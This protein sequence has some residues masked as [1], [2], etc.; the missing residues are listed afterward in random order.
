MAAAMAVAVA[1]AVVVFLAPPVLA[2]LVLGGHVS[3]RDSSSVSSVQGSPEQWHGLGSRSNAR[4]E[5]QLSGNTIT[6]CDGR[7]GTRTTHRGSCS[8]AK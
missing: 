3:A 2:V 8:S 1:V 4:L 7:Q 5:A 6:R